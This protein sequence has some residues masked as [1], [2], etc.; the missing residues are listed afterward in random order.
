VSVKFGFFG[1]SCDLIGNFELLDELMG[2]EKHLKRK[3]QASNAFKRI[4]QALDSFLIGL[5]FEPGREGLTPYCD[6]GSDIGNKCCL[7]WVV[8][9]EGRP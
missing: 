8:R 4:K 2:K 5:I 6:Y 9:M 1:L 7:V 3:F